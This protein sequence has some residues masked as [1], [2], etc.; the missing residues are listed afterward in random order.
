MAITQQNPEKPNEAVGVNP[1]NSAQITVQPFLFPGG[2]T[3]PAVY[4]LAL[5][6]AGPFRLYLEQDGSFSTDL[7]GDHYWLLA[8]TILPETQY[9]QALTGQV[10]E[11]D[12]PKTEM[13]ERALNL[14]EI[15]IIVF[16]LPEV[17]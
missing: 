7:Y 1:G 3:S 14:N 5:F 15:D 4:D 16:S 6:Q 2:T 10:D 13:V 17:V 11:N 9:D 12:Q 8:E